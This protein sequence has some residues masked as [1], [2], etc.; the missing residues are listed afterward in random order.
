[1]AL[2]KRLFEHV[3]EM[4]YTKWWY[5]DDATDECY[6]ETV[7]DQDHYGEANAT[8]RKEK[9]GTRM[10]DGM[11]HVAQ[12]P[13]AL[14]WKLKTRGVFDDQRDFRRWWQ[15]DEAAPF[16]VRELWMGRVTRGA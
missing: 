15:S 14:Y 2:R 3:P 13:M 6:I 9:H 12:I 1:M 10:G 11:E 7:W 8:L 5:Y 4:G 16:K